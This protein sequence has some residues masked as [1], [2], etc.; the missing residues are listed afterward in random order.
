M[1]ILT[2]MLVGLLFVATATAQIPDYSQFKTDDEENNIE[3]FK[4]V[5]PSVVNITNSRLLRS[6]YSFNPQEVPQ[7][8][9]TGFVW[10]KYNRQIA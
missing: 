7:G 10:D 1:K 5:S 8:S 3:I 2:Y 6:F 9:G 4:S